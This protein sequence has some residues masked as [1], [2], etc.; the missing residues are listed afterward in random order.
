MYISCS[1]V[2]WR[3]V[4][5]GRE[6]KTRGLPLQGAAPRCRQVQIPQYEH[7]FQHNILGMFPDKF[8]KLGKELGDELQ[9]Y[10]AVTLVSSCPE[11]K[12]FQFQ[13]WIQDFPQHPERE[14]TPTQTI[15]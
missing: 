4:G 11:G 8:M 9:S 3:C 1:V 14:E 13:C 5:V 6:H 7:S 2:A 12:K 15:I 10:R